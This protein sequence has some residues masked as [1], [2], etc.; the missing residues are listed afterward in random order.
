MTG[1][2]NAVAREELIGRARALLPG[3]ASR[4][5]VADRIRRLPEETQ[6]E[7]MEAGLYR[8]Y[9]PE[10][11][12][13]YESDYA[14]QIDLAAELGTACGSTAWVHSV[15]A[16]HSWMHGMFDAGAQDAVWGGDPDA[17][18]SGSTPTADSRI[19]P[20]DGG[21][22]LNGTWT[23]ASGVDFCRWNHF[24]M[25]TPRLDRDG[26]EH[27]YG[28][29][30]VG[31]VELIND[32]YTTG[33]RGTG[34]R[35]MVCRDLFIAEDWTIRSEACRG[36]PTRGSAV[37][38]GALYRMPLFALF[39]KGIVAPAVGI[40]RGALALA[41]ERLGGQ[42]MQSGAKLAGEPTAQLRIGEAAA[43]I[44]AAWTLLRRDCEEVHARAE[45]GE[46]PS[47]EERHRWRR[48]DA[49]AGKL[50]VRAVD[51]LMA[52]GG[53]AGNAED[54]PLQRHWRDMH[55]LASHIALAWDA[56]GANYGRILLD[57]PT[58]DGKL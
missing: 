6:A 8:I 14:L 45:A 15:V 18:I 30:A 42:R 46:V 50:L 52:L 44:D 21:Y 38:P 19:D 47:L 41:V 26:L 31:D 43:E 35:S 55:T 20:V 23:L 28:L 49:Y 1:G 29:A 48:N 58:R 16:S 34:S 12:G 22:L 24:N 37:N 5:A 27:R 51:R 40:A 53:A 10:R 9:L 33:L 3:I 57:L 25:M 17:L 2:A 4:A 36:G 11:Y 56:Q 39:G 32:W 7:L 13:G 54:S